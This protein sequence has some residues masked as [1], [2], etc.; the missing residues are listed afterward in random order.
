MDERLEK[1][2]KGELKR[3][4]PPPKLENLVRYEDLLSPEYKKLWE[5]TLEREENWDE[6]EAR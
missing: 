5:I 1:F 4:G 6:E 2:L 3:K